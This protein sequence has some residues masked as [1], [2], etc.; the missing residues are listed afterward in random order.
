MKIH[1]ETQKC[2]TIEFDDDEVIVLNFISKGIEVSACD[3]IE[4]VLRKC[5][6]HVGAAFIEDC[7]KPG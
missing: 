2:Y 3:M 5:M 6:E 4:L 1:C 7:K